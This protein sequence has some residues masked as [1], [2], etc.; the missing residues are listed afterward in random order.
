MQ[1]VSLH[2][3]GKY[4]QICESKSG[5][6]LRAKDSQE[7]EDL[8]DALSSQNQ[9]QRDLLFVLFLFAEHFAVMKKWEVKGKNQISFHFPHDDYCYSLKVDEK[10][11]MVKFIV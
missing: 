10:N 6:K 1:K 2:T 5:L 11:L 3:D 4:F 8:L 9:E 7:G